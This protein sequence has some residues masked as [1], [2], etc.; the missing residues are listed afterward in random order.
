MP[1]DDI[2]QNKR[3]ILQNA[4]L[5]KYLTMVAHELEN[6]GQTMTDVIK[7]WPTVEITPT[8]NSVKEIIWRP[9][10]NMQVGKKSTTELTTSEV[11]KIYQIV[12]MFLSR[13]FGISLPFPSQEN[14]EEYIKSLDN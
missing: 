12:S 10:Q 5:H 8:M 2:K 11:D 13:Q 1:I 4:S 14:T 9:V 7:K 3:T 6:Q